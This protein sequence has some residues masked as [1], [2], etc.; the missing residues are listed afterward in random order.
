M[1][2]PTPVFPAARSGFQRLR[3][4]IVCLALIPLSAA[5]ALGG[6]E[7][8]T[9]SLRVATY[10]LENYL[11]Q[12]RLVDGVWHPE[13]PKPEVEKAA[14][15]AII[16]HASPDILALQEMGGRPF[17]KELQ[18]DLRREGLDYPHAVWMK[19]PDKVRHLALLSREPV[20]KV[21]RHRGFDF[22]YLDER[23]DLRRG[24]LE[25]VFG[26]G[27]SGMPRWHLFVLHLKSKW[28]ERDDDP[29]ADHLRAREAEVARNYIL[30]KMPDP[31]AARYLIAGDLN[32]SPNSSPVRRFLT[33]GDLELGILLPTGDDRGH[34][35]THFWEREQRYSRRDYLI[36]SPGLF[37][38]VIDGRTRIVNHPL[39]KTASDHR[40]V[41]LD[42]RRSEPTR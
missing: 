10:N 34:L 13:Y 18:E 3:R 15:R 6:I 11:I 31:Q 16:R 40:L 12:D 28:T 2:E 27:A 5:A 32:D 38:Q 39:E 23:R 42:L 19:S 8:G 36:P 37:D 25:V 35:W 9:G 41:Y 4:R 22:G 33:R 17:L 1:R 24:L 30:E 14:L 29:N 20:R 26:G 21:L 7:T